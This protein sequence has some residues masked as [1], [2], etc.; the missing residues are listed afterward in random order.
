MESLGDGR[1]SH[2]LSYNSLLANLYRDGNDSVG[3]HSDDEK[4]LG[5]NPMIASVSL[6]ASRRFSLKPQDKSRGPLHIELHSGD[7][8]IM[9]GETQHHWIH[10]I[11]KTRMPVTARINLTFRKI[12]VK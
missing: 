10:Q 1:T 8:I 3:W 11:P 5:T 7:V 9:G 2:P 12:H 6:G 4:E